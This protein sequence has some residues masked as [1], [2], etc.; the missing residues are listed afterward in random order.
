MSERPYVCLDIA[1]LY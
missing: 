1:S